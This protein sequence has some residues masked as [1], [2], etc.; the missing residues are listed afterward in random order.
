[1][2]FV[3]LSS[4][5]Q[6]DAPSDEERVSNAKTP[7]YVTGV[8]T[9]SMDENIELRATSQFQKKVTVKA[10]A[11]GYIDNVTINIGDEVTLG[12]VLFT[13]KTKEASAISNQKTTSD[14]SLN[15]S[16]ILKIKAQK[17]GII[18]TLDHQ[19]G[20]YVQ[21]GD[22]LGIISERN[23]FV[24][25][26]DVP[27]ELHQYV[28]AGTECLVIF[29]DD[30]AMKGV[31]K[32]AMPSVDAVAQTQSFVITL[33]GNHNLPENLI[34]KVRIKKSTKD[35][36][37]VLAKSTI[38]ADE[39]E[40]QFWIMKLINDSIAIKVPVKKGIEAD[41]QV[42]IIEPKFTKDDRIIY[43]GNYGLGDTAKVSIQNEGGER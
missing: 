33:Y 23:S 37:Q 12:E 1:M 7:V 5:K 32:Y 21:D 25:I 26:L 2:V 8:Q 16:G 3:A 4:C 27:F 43:K 9:T 22:Q 36:A 31:V 35:K 39:T 30:M 11:T 15:F 10:N 6:K 28:K 34:A 19:K 17:A 14:T 40:T 38:M 18:T 41:D 13:L 24:F 20:D 29:P 42:E